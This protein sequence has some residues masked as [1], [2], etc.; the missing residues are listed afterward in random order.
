MPLF[1]EL[2]TEE[3]DA[4]IKAR[5]NKPTDCEPINYYFL[6]IQPAQNKPLNLKKNYKQNVNNP[7]LYTAYDKSLKQQVQ[8]IEQARRK[9]N[10]NQVWPDAAYEHDDASLKMHVSINNL[11]NLDDNIVLG[12][13]EL[14]IKEAQDPNNNLGMRFKS[15]YPDTSSTQPR[16]ALNDQFTIYFDKYSSIADM[17]RLGEKIEAYLKQ[18]NIPENAQPRGEKDKFGL[19]SFVSLR[20]DSNRLNQQYGLFH[21][22]DLE[23][24]K[25]FSSHKDLG[26]LENIPLCAFEVAFNNIIISRD[27][28]NLRAGLNAEQGLNADDSRKVQ[29]Q[30]EQ[31]LRNPKEFMNPPRQGVPDQ[32]ALDVEL[33]VLKNLGD[34]SRKINEIKLDLG[35]H[36]PKEQLDTLI[37]EKLDFLQKLSGNND[38]RRAAMKNNANDY[39]N[40]QALIAEKVVQLQQHQ[41]RQHDVI[42]EVQVPSVHLVRKQDRAAQPLDNFLQELKAEAEKEKEK[43]KVKTNPQGIKALQFIEKALPKLVKSSASNANTA[44]T[45][46]RTDE[47]QLAVKFDT[48][49]MRDQFIKVVWPD[50]NKRP[51]TPV[52]NDTV[53]L[54]DGQISLNLKSRKEQFSVEFQ[55]IVQRDKFN[56][57]LGLN[58][59][60]HHINNSPALPFIHFQGENILV[61]GQSIQTQLSENFHKNKKKPQLG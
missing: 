3:F 54:I 36:M 42:P 46:Y 40:F 50:A 32:A 29:E 49:E 60:K 11:G 23:L 21:F 37:R 38:I 4:K 17:I 39:L 55:D 30:F 15:V 1:G 26:Q 7:G 28:N 34:L 59:F 53:L 43:E 24:E 41:Q 13:I 16:F 8:L 9:L 52:G 22:F 20:F 25:F 44:V 33:A 51:K 47:N 14:L 5:L 57:Y 58:N 2:S 6:L 27:I 61:K 10:A 56:E 35:G 31:M 12:L 48:K 19:N 45:L 18:N